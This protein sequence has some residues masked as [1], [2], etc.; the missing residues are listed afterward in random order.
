MVAR[1]L[2]KIKKKNLNIGVPDTKSNYMLKFSR[3]QWSY[4]GYCNLKKQVNTNKQ[5]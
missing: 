1:K 3:D 5:I 4:I 2:V